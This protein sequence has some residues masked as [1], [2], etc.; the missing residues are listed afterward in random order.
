MHN[1]VIIITITSW[2]I[3]SVSYT[4][5]VE[6]GLPLVEGIF[7]SEEGDL[8]SITPPSLLIMSARQESAKHNTY[9]WSHLCP[10]TPRVT[11]VAEPLLLLRLPALLQPLPPLLQ[12]VL[13][14][15]LLVIPGERSDDCQESLTFKVPKS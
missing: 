9:L 4:L 10:L 5:A 6:E 7:R 1:N 12:L 11:Q 3:I 14:Q 8:K 13:Q 15:L 2:I